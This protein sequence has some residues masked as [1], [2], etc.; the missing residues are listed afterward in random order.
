LME[1][2]K[3]CLRTKTSQPQTGELLVK[4]LFVMLGFCT[5]LMITRAFAIEQNFIQ[6][7]I[8]NS[9]AAKSYHVEMYLKDLSDERIA[10]QNIHNVDWTVDYINPDRFSVEQYF[11]LEKLAD[12]WITIGNIT[13]RF[14][15]VFWIESPMGIEPEQQTLKLNKLMLID[16]YF[17]ILTDNKPINESEDDRSVIINYSLTNWRSFAETLKFKDGYSCL[18]TMWLNKKN[19][20]IEETLIQIYGVGQNGEKQSF[21]IGQRFSDYNSNIIINKPKI[22]KFDK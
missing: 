10:G 13:Y 21:E 18:L 22:I 20:L 15:N 3:K 9:K 5:C 7:C 12:K 14:Y 11:N 6:E 19:R 17:E 1:F 4:R 8:N 16:K 2:F